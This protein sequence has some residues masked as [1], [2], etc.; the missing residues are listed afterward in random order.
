VRV[1]LKRAFV[2]LAVVLVLAACAL[3]AGVLWPER[4]SE[5]PPAAELLVIENVAVVDAETGTLRPGTTVEVENGRI[6]RVA[7]AA[8]SSGSGLVVDG[9]GKFLIPGLWDMHVHLASKLSPHLHLPLVV[10]HGVTAVRDMADC[11]NPSDR[12]LAC[13]EDKRS[14]NE[15]V[16]RGELVGPRVM[17]VASFIVHG[18]SRRDERFPSF[19]T[20]ANENEARELVRYAKGRSFDF[21]KVYDSVP[22][23][24]YLAL[25]DEAKAQSL[26]VVGH[27]PRA[28]SAMEA[29]EA[30]QRS[31]E[32][33]RLFLEECYPGA[34]TLRTE[35]RRYTTADRKAMVGEH[36]ASQ[37]DKLFAVMR[38]NGTWF[39][40]THVTRKMDAFADDA[41]YRDDPR[42]RYI[43]PFQRMVWSEDADGMVASDPSPEGRKTFMDFYEK[44]LELTGAAYR[45]GVPLLAGTDANDTYAF[46]GSG[47]HD[48]LEEL[49]KAGLTPSEALVAATVS[50]ARYFGVE[51]EYGSI[52][53]GKTAD[54]VLL[55][56]NP[57]TDIRNTRSIEAV[58]LGGRLYRR[59]DLDALL[60]HVEASVGSL[61]LGAKLLW[62]YLL[63]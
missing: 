16:G 41:E 13:L 5:A 62:A 23:D 61:T 44:G 31:L 12:F 18:P 1:L 33:A 54:M 10:A 38:E 17:G 47:L 30:G 36:D 14:W 24:V 35:R 60:A 6:R 34:E 32:H 56:E 25:L 43:H 45:A 20:P 28:V 2:L 4:L 49:V 40:P 22:R 50:P 46:P 27:R 8:G 7:P 57:L 29:S 52:A 59:E 55:R 21:L 37:C 19:F 63:K 58:V 9:S 39:V 15:A 26:E 11:E 48:E 53:E 51:R 3:T 42:L